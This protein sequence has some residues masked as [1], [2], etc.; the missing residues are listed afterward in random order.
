MLYLDNSA[1]TR[2]DPEV[3]EVM[4][5][6][7]REEFGNPSSKYYTLAE[8]AKHAVNKAR[9]QVSLL[10]G[11]EIDEVIF[12]SGATES[13]NMVLKGVADFYRDKGNH[14]ITTKVEHPSVLDTCE[15]L[16]KKGF[17]VT[18]LDVDEYG[19]VKLDQLE[20]K[21]REDK[22]IL[23]SVLWGNNEIGSLN[24]I[25]D[26][27]KICSIYEVF[28]H[29]DATQVIG[30]MS[31]SLQDNPGIRFLSMSAHKINGPKGIGVC[32]IRKETSTVKTKITPLLHGGGQ[33]NGYRSGTLAVHNIVGIGKAAEL[34]SAR[35]LENQAKLLELEQYLVS[36]LKDKFGKQVQ[37]NNDFSNKIHG[38]L[39]VR[40]VGSKNNEILIKQL[41]PYMALSTGSAC[42]S[43]K[44]SHV[45]Q[46]L[47][48]SQSEIAQT[49]RISLSPHTT[50]EQLDIFRGIN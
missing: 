6:Y 15:Y 1:T 24:N 48:K 19:R 12:T 32:V 13:N 4:L 30:K 26:I 41:A 2:V 47:G 29:T 31:I 37:F 44:P 38:I 21:I 36:I 45:L 7:L 43:G 5:P 9:E 35:V 42:S 49:I 46:A 14:I 28:F 23:V 40:F 33:E 17:Q 34:A 8:N 10:L 3:L 20:E 16:E 25:Q 50:T 39:S 27:A 22:P 18:Y 11:C